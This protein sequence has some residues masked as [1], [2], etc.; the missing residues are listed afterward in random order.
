[1]PARPLAAILIFA[2]SQFASAASGPCLFQPEDLKAILGAEPDPGKAYKDP[3]GNESLCTYGMGGKLG[4]GFTVRVNPRQV[5]KK[6]FDSVAKLAQTMSGKPPEMIA[7]VG[8]SA[9]Y[10]SGRAAVLV[11]SRMIEFTGMNAATRKDP[12]TNEEIVKFLKLAVERAK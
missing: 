11:G 2:A 7:G 9:F 3:M 4:G 1:M 12:L 6:D 8:D 10:V 5:E